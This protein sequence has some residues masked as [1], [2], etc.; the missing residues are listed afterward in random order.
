MK[1]YP[2]QPHVK[3]ICKVAG[4]SS[5]TLYREVRKMLKVLAK[6]EAVNDGD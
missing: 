1:I 4:I 3:D 5:K 2:K 6:K